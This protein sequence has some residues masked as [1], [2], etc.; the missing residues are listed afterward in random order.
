MLLLLFIPVLFRVA[1][2]FNVALHAQVAPTNKIVGSV[3]TTNGLRSAFKDRV[4]VDKV[5]IF[6]PFS[7][8]NFLT[9]N[10]DL[11]L[12]EGWFPS[13][14]TFIQLA[15][16]HCKSCT[17][18]F[19]CLDHIY[20][21][22]NIVTS[23][24]VD[25]YLTNSKQL[26]PILSEYNPV[27]FML[28]A[29][30][31]TK[32]H[33][34][35]DVLSRPYGAVYVGAGGEMVLHKPK[36]VSMLLAAVSSGLQIYG[37]SWNKAFDLLRDQ[38]IQSFNDGSFNNAEL[39]AKQLE[40]DSLEKCWKG[41]LPSD[42]LQTLYSNAEVVFSSTIK[43]QSQAG[44][45]NNRVFEALSCGAV[46]ISDQ[47]LPLLEDE[48]INNVILIAGNDNI[49]G[50]VQRYI[51]GLQKNSTIG[52]SIRANARSFIERRHTW[53]HRAVEILDFVHELNNK[54]YTSFSEGEATADVKLPPSRCDAQP[55]RRSN[56]PVMLWVVSKDLQFHP[57]YLFVVS[58]MRNV[59]EKKQ[60]YCV[61]SM[62]ETLFD[63]YM[64]I[65]RGKNSDWLA[66]FDTIL[67]V[68]TPF[69][70]LDIKLMKIKRPV[71]KFE[72][73][74]EQFSRQQK[75]VSYIIGFNTTKV[76]E[77][78]NEMNALVSSEPGLDRSKDRL[79]LYDHYDMAWYR[80]KFEV[81]LLLQYNHSSSLTEGGSVLEQEYY[82]GIF[83]SAIRLQHGF[84]LSSYSP[85][86]NTHLDSRT[87]Y[88][89]L[90]PSLTSVDTLEE[91]GSAPRPFNLTEDKIVLFVC[92]YGNFS[93]NHCG[94]EW[95]LRMVSLIDRKNRNIY[96]EQML[97]YD[98]ALQAYND[99]IAEDAAF[100]TVYVPP[101]R[102]VE[103]VET[104]YQ[105]LLVGGTWDKWLHLP[106]VISSDPMDVS[107]LV[108]V[109]E[110]RIGR[111]MDLI[112]KHTRHLIYVHPQVEYSTSSL[113][114][115][116]VSTEWDVL[117]PIVAA[118]VANVYIQLVHVNDHIMGIMNDE[119]YAWDEVYWEQ[120]V[121]QGLARTHGLGSSR[122]GL[123]VFSYSKATLSWQKD[124]L[125]LPQYE[126]R[127][128]EYWPQ[129]CT[130]EDNISLHAQMVTPLLG[131]DMTGEMSFHFPVLIS[132]R[133]F[134]IGRDGEC[135]VHL[136]NGILLVCYISSIF[137][138][139]KLHMD[140]NHGLLE[141][142]SGR[143]MVNML[144]NDYEVT[145]PLSVSLRGTMFGDVIYSKRV[146][147]QLTVPLGLWDMRTFGNI[148]A[149]CSHFEPRNVNLSNEPD[150]EVRGNFADN[151][152][153][154]HLNEVLLSPNT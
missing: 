54:R 111:A 1:V 87:A 128:E 65:N 113:D 23:L 45:I 92:F 121:S 21:G 138:G 46:V 86:E 136:D 14:H 52:N 27:Q 120:T 30:D 56:I 64:D 3:I 58:F 95:R 22:L 77:Y 20:P 57:D 40:L 53:N 36:L 67:A 147:L 25:G 47:P 89:P 122:S 150:S 41:I 109:Q 125:D 152:F 133:Y 78:F 101:K 63:H 102:P 112:T 108:L 135:C 15:R 142:L 16:D 8:H 76:A 10:W 144:D 6:Y 90:E 103:P 32:F 149:F 96:V 24:D 146:H 37:S 71:H 5:S 39:E 130:V 127:V 140:L 105:T 49:T 100:A 29:A 119:C 137:A 83:I 11:V 4:D 148:E 84:G 7:Y 94:S 26:L 19:I 42:Q 74:G 129:R 80:S 62:N 91:Q 110:G 143:N 93:A 141:Y 44:M 60:L 139:V 81:N 104:V 48:D 13:I 68:I 31:S 59:I 151:W 17:V 97:Q 70:T 72:N 75:V 145:L 85:M 106:G 69:D 18:V 34:I 73:M 51:S 134:E 61:V 124:H 115:S 99:K 66:A 9:T 43:T 33:P 131:R 153:D 12:I 107:R 2:C 132:P 55:N 35:S 82:S 154:V 38:L 123:T 28:L 114:S 98:L 118:A 116:R 79:F 88:E 126:P 117:W 50:N